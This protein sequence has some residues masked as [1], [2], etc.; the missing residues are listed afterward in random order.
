MAI[1]VLQLPGVK[2]KS[3]IRPQKC[4]NC[5][6]ETLRRWG[7]VRKP[8]RDNCIRTVQA[9]RYCCGHCRRTFRH[10]PVGV[11]R[12]DQTQ[13]LRKLAAILWVL[14][15]SLRGVRLALSAFGLKLSHM[16]VWQD[17]QEQANLLG[18]RRQWQ[19]VRVL[20][21][22][23]AYPLLQGKK[24]PE[25]I[26]VDLGN[27]RPVAIAQVDEANPQAVKRFLEPL[28]QRLEVSV[29][30]TDDLAS[31]RPVAEKLGLEHQVCQFHVRRWVGRMLRELRTSLPQKGAACWTRSKRW[32]PALV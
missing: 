30:V 22:E 20:G 9:F 16:S 12:A 11:D 13:R 32:Q 28:V 25:L 7:R 17:V 31:F 26:A 6:G 15:L 5:Q 24:R 2:R 4:P 3:E 18:K 14:G 23:G 8:V 1:I 10:C 21:V 27:G 29:I 19:G